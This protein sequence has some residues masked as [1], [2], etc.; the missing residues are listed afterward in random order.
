MTDNVY[1]EWIRDYMTKWNRDGLTSGTDAQPEIHNRDGIWWY[2]APRPRRLHRCTPW[3]QAWSGPENMRYTERC[4]CGSIRFR[5]N[6]GWSD[7][8]SSRRERRP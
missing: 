6:G 3:T 2:D 5:R 1:A 4:A 7:R 8:N